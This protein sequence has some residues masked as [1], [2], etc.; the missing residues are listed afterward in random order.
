LI[1]SKINLQDKD[2]IKERRNKRIINWEKRVPDLYK[3]IKVSNDKIMNIKNNF[4]DKKN[5]LKIAYFNGEDSLFEKNKKAF[6]IA[7]IFIL[8]GYSS[9]NIEIFDFTK[10]STMI[11]W[12]DRINEYNKL[13]NPDLK[14]LIVNN[15]NFESVRE[16]NSNFK[17]ELSDMFISKLNILL[18]SNPEISCIFIGNKLEINQKLATGNLFINLLIDN[19]FIFPKK[20]KIEEKKQLKQVN[21]LM[22]YLDIKGHK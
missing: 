19:H 10:T 8:L 21:G 6:E 4:Y 15:V 14:L 17:Q 1:L 7:K 12:S 13:D 22:S 18:G 3:N 20:K 2:L 11:E 5:S 16:S 9:N